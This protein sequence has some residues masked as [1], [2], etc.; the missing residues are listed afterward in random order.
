VTDPRNTGALFARDSSAG[1]S[2]ARDFPAPD[3]SP[4][5]A[6][7][8]HPRSGLFVALE[9][10]EGAG[11]STQLRHLAEALEAQGYRVRQGREPG[12]TPLGEAVRSILL[13][14][15]E[16]T[17][18]APAEL[19][20]MLTARSAFVQEV[21]A[22]ALQ[23]GAIVLADRFEG[24]TF[25][26]QGYGRGLDLA[27]VRGLNAFATGGVHPD[28]TIILDLPVEEG[29]ARQRR[30][31][32]SGDRIESGGRAFHERVRAGYHALAAG[33]A[34]VHLIEATDSV[35]AVHRSILAV[36]QPELECRILKREAIDRS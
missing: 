1:T 21:V 33:D 29:E 16:L 28:V 14:R 10:G 23:E 30:A 22:P 26:Y 5:A 3:P 34:S 6:P 12:G 36:L 4:P 31:G 18:A 15:E 2:S 9:G 27:T 24:S 17:I 35:E 11:K 13:D 7:P 20:L 8:P 32:K 19:L 25:A